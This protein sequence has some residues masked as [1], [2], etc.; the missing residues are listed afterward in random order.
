MQL[1]YRRRRDDATEVGDVTAV[2]E[3]AHDLERR[4][5]LGPA[6]DEL[7]G[8]AATL[9]VRRLEVPTDGEAI[10]RALV[11]AAAGGPEAL[12]RK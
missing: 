12:G 6:R 1:H 4:F 9:E 11:E 2:V 10:L 3:A 8:L 5:D 7:T